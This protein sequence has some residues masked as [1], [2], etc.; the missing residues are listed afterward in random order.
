MAIRQLV[1]MPEDL[2]AARLTLNDID[3]LTRIAASARR[4]NHVEGFQPVSEEL[5]D[6][7]GPRFSFVVGGSTVCDTIQDIRELGP[8]LL[9]DGTALRLILLG[10]LV[11]AFGERIVKAI[12]P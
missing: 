11:Y 3:E 8:R 7:N 6:E 2:P 10:G 1:E 12:W 4:G 9:E 5:T